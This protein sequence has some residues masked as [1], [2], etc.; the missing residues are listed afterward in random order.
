MRSSFFV[1]ARLL[2]GFPSLVASHQGDAA[3]LLADIGIPASVLEDP[4]LSF[5]L[6]DFA[7]LLAHAANRLALPDF[8]I[9]LAAHMDIS[10]LGTAALIA[11]QSE[12]VE[13]ALRS[14]LRSLPYLSPGLFGEVGRDTDGGYVRLWHDRKIGGVGREHLTELTI[15][16]AM[17]FLRMAAPGRTGA[18]WKLSFE[19]A[20]KLDAAYY[21]K[22][23]GC[24]VRFDQSEDMLQ[25][26]A[27]VLDSRI[28]S[29]NAA[30]RNSG[31][32]YVRHLVRR[33]SLALNRQVEELVG[34]HLATGKCTLPLIADRLQLPKHEV[35]RRLA[36]Q[37]LCFEDIVDQLRRESA[38]RYLPQTAIPLAHIAECLG[39]TSQTSFTRACRRWFGEA[40]QTLRRR[41]ATQA[42]GA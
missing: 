6:E 14:M 7:R 36:A 24:A 19:H 33:H 30:L 18:D 16:I 12:T 38:E 20:P 31:E 23:F 22:A 3:A 39:Y 15:T 25:F 8:G 35:Q 17:S 37:G 41:L 42:P 27:S 26:P 29:S 13:E 1:R 4:E 34:S 2:I 21:R 32:R 5:P 10:V 28:E 9:R 40:P 11:L